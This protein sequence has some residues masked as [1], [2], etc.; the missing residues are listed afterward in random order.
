MEDFMNACKEAEKNF[1]PNIIYL[2]S[3]NIDFITNFAVGR[4]IILPAFDA[5]IIGVFEDNESI[6]LQKIEKNVSMDIGILSKINEL[7]VN[8]LAEGL[9]NEKQRVLCILNTKLRG[10]LFF[11]AKDIGF[12]K[13]MEKTQKKI[14]PDLFSSLFELSL[15]I[16][17]E[18]REGVRFG[19]IFVV[20]DVNEMLK[21]TY[22]RIMNPFKGHSEEE[23]T[24]LK[25]ENWQTIKQFAQ[26]D[27][28]CIVNKNGLIEGAGYYIM[29]KDWTTYLRGYGGRHA[30]C[31]S[32]TKTT[33]AI[34]FCISSDGNLTIFDEGNEIYRIK[35]I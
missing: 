31:A 22:E 23:R 7:L 32:I 33:N 18:G 6:T 21:N 13:V 10:I 3:E 30:A 19:A 1:K 24:I 20:G 2:I 35:V 27:G 26:L 15:E 14:S 4:K 34:A 11:E 9:I 29:I 8:A 17:R 12:Y 28:A 25:R 16:A 5:K